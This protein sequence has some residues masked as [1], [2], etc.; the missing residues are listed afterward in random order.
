MTRP[1]ILEG[2]RRTQP[3]WGRFGDFASLESARTRAGELR[4][5][6]PWYVRYSFRVRNR[7]SGAVI[8]IK[9]DG[10]TK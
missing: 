9:S 2:R 6:T 5:N 3:D 1:W 10:P 7:D 4:A 8:E